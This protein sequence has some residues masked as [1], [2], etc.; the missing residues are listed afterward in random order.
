MATRTAIVG[1]PGGLHARP[2]ALFVAA[3]QKQPVPVTIRTAERP[4]APATSMLAVLALKATHGTEVVLEAQGDGADAALDTLAALIAR[5]LDIETRQGLGV[6]P[7]QAAGP[8]YRMVAPPGLPPS[9]APGPD[10]SDRALAA[11]KHVATELASRATFAEPTAAKILGAQAMMIEDPTLA[12]AVSQAVESGLDGPHAIDH[13]F[14]AHRQTFLEAGGYLS[15]RITDLDDLR[16]RAIAASLGLPMPGIP[17]PGTP[18]VLVARDLAPADTATL[19]PGRVLAI[20]TERG[21]PTSHM[22]ILARTLGI[23]AVVGCA[24]AMD[25]ADGTIVTVDGTSGTVDIGVDQ[26]TVDA[27]HEREAARQATLAQSHGAGRTADGYPVALLANIGSARD[28][29]PDTEGVGLFRTELLYLDRTEAPSLDEQIATYTDVFTRN[30][31]RRMVIRTLDAG[32]DKP[33]PFVRHDPEPNP[34]LGMRGLR[35]SRRDPQLLQTQLAAISAASRATGADVW[36]MAP[37]VATPAEAAGFAARCR[38]AGIARAGVMIEIPGAALR[39]KEILA[40]CDFLSIGTND[41]S[42]YTFAADRESGDLADLNDPWQ[43]ALLQLIALCGKAGAAAGKP[44]G[45]CGEAAADPHLAPVLVGMGISSLSMSARLIAACR[46]SLAQH[47]FAQ[48]RQL[49]EAALAANDARA[50]R[51][52]GASLD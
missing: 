3:A 7:G 6:S 8:T 1:S 5:N 9:T 27:T 50:A 36:V 16:D 49:A 45:V 52:A 19:Q 17:D 10:T 22:A 4:A 37:M 51:A 20:V 44:V 34:A 26:S 42:Q 35:L 38:S 25:I 11:L 15:D 47:S 21:G 29:S 32:A 28:L 31:G 14:A 39:A 40:V 30:D 33:L 24:G 12:V 41:L 48:C 43:P 2:A 46:E 13:A 18:F 23:A